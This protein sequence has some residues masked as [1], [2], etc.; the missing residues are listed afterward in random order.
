MFNNFSKLKRSIFAIF[1]FIFCFFTLAKPSLAYEGTEGPAY[2]I[3]FQ[4]ALNSTDMNLQSFVNETFKAVGGSIFN[5]FIGPI[6]WACD[7][8]KEG[9]DHS[10]CLLSQ[11]ND[12]EFYGVLPTS[13]MLFSGLSQSQPASGIH[14]LADLGK[15]MG[16]VQPAFAASFNNFVAF[17][18]LQS[19]WTTFR[20][21]SYII[22][23]I[24]LIVMGFAIM[25]RMK[26]S[27]QA[28]ITIQ[29]ALPKVVISLILITFSYAI[30]GLILDISMFINSLISNIF[31]H[32]F[33]TDFEN[34]RWIFSSYSQ[35]LS[36]M[37]EAQPVLQPLIPFAAAQVYGTAATTVFFIASVRYF[38]G[39]GILV[40][41]ILGLLVT[42]AYLRALWTLIRAFAMIVINLIFAPIRILLGVLPGSNA[43]GDWFKDL[44]SNVAILP[45]MLCLY[46]V[47]NYLILAG[48][49]SRSNVITSNGGIIGSGFG[50]YGAFWMLEGFFLPII[51]IFILLLIPKVSDI[52]QSFITKKPFQYGTAIG[53][54]M[55]PVMMGGKMAV[56]GGMPHIVENIK[57]KKGWQDSNNI[58]GK[59]L[60]AISDLIQ[61]RLKK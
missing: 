57:N 51:G 18:P 36:N 6:K 12:T 45:G 7:L 14:Y 44:I 31:V 61:S 11:G 38:G 13:I 49:N 22:F 20:N 32:M 15:K 52:I 16:V 37:K 5:L 28:V 35:L 26:I 59:G 46:F 58:K 34:W 39:F 40:L 1:V 43:I 42:I 48:V 2:I 19:I 33:N 29:S 27:P 50:I 4:E 25:F 54:T 17:E 47:G 21:F 55:G 41:L 8:F 24:I 60:D 23:V 56:S 30:V 9:D 10:D 53:E 3:E